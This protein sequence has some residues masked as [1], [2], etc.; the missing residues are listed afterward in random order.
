[1]NNY[2]FGPDVDL[3]LSK[4]FEN[5]PDGARILSSKAFC[6]Y[7]FRISNRNLDGKFSFAVHDFDNK[8]STYWIE[9]CQWLNVNAVLC[10]AADKLL[11]YKKK[12]TRF[13]KR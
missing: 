12:Q 6:P 7:N 3:K 2:V 10:H 1:M 4:M 9:F 8:V 13:S 11:F 5:L